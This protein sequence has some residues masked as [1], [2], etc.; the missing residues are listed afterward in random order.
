MEI[1]NPKL[2]RQRSRERLPQRLLL[3]LLIVTIAV[4]VSLAIGTFGYVELAGALPIDAFLNAAML[5]G[6]MGPVGE[7]H[8]TVGKLFAAFYA[9][10]AGLFFIIA[11]GFVTTPLVHAMLLNF[12]V[13]DAE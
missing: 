2:M 8:G 11:A 12:H 13:E 7:I 5:L 3:R 4:A 6:G 10:Y 9:L 1:H